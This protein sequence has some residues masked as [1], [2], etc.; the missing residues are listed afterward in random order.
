MYFYDSENPRPKRRRPKR[1]ATTRSYVYNQEEKTRTLLVPYGRTSCRRNTVETVLL[2]YA[3]RA[4]Q[5][6]R[7]WNIST[8]PHRLSIRALIQA[9][10]ISQRMPLPF[11]YC[12]PLPTLF[13]PMVRTNEGICVWNGMERDYWYH[14]PFAHIDSCVTVVAKNNSY[15][16]GSSGGH[17]LASDTSAARNATSREEEL[18]QVRRRQQELASERALQAAKLRREKELAEKDRKNHV[19]KKS[20]PKGGDKL[21][22]RGGT[23]K[24]SADA[25]AY[26]PLQP[27]N[28]HS[29]GYRYVTLWQHE[30]CFLPRNVRNSIF[31]F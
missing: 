28:S 31:Y 29:S 6:N 30:E 27:L 13:A 16:G 22:G 4:Q 24:S 10:P 14:H 20:N 17:V 15:L 11:L 18:R 26:T 21:G 1:A 8:R 7:P 2:E 19:A 9:W 5:Q 25:C 12:S 23:T 3:G